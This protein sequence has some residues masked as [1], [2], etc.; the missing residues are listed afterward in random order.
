MVTLEWDQEPSRGDHV[1]PER[2]LTELPAAP[3]LSSASSSTSTTS[4]TASEQREPRG[5]EGPFQ[6][7]AGLLKPS[8]LCFPLARCTEEAGLVFSAWI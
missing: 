1:S 6:P 2:P 4:L 3:R 7:P 5:D 8:H